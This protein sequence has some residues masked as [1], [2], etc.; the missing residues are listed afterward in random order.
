M[1]P[2]RSTSTSARSASRSVA[3]RAL[4]DVSVEIRAGSV[5]AFVGENGAGKSTL[6]KIVAGVL[7]QDQ[8]ELLLRGEPVASAR[9]CGARAGIA[10]V[11]QE[12]PLVPQ[13]TVA[14]NVFL[15][16]EPRR[17]G[18]VRRG[19][20]SSIGSGAS[21]PAPGFE[22]PANATRRA[23]CRSRCSSRSRSCGRSPAMPSS[24]CSTS[25][26]RPSRV[27]DPALPRDRPGPAA[28][29]AD[30]H[31]R[32][33]FPRRGARARRHHDRPARRPGRPDRP[34]RSGDRGHA[35]RGDARPLGRAHLPAEAGAGRRCAGRASV[36][37]LRA[38]GCT[39]SR[40]RSGPAR[41]WRSPGSSAPGRS[42]LARA[43]F[44]AVPADRPAICARSHGARR[45]P[46]WASTPGRSP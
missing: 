27:R 43:I 30:R 1:A 6:G 9:P 31:P 18:F 13:R 11:A 22:V 28:R 40:S 2:A 14:E 4:H 33:P 10:M 20:S 5:H 8:G 12:V 23:R 15:G 19:E 45:Q 25:P 16:I 21:S 42:E 46:T 17:F 44:G 3:T 34:G 35:R 39:A 36:R 38:A 32:L 29:R 24:S 37:D 7:P 26:R 41:S